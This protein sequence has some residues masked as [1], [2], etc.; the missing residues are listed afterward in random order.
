MLDEAA[1]VLAALHLP[2]D[3]PDAYRGCRLTD[4]ARRHP[5]TV[6]APHPGAHPR[7]LPDHQAWFAGTEF[8]VDESV[9]VPRSPLAE[10]VET[11]FGPRW[12]L[13]PWRGCL[14]CAP[15]VAV[16]ASPPR[17]TCRTRT[18]TWR[19][20]PRRPGGGGAQHR[21]PWPGRPG[22][23]DQVGPLRRA[24]GPTLRPDRQ[25]PALCQRRGLAHPAAGVPP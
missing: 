25:Q 4:E 1:L 8:C 10:L 23:G 17:S 3:L 13:T 16:S 6:R 22:A 20:S 9:L 19:T 12:S 2:P 15:A 14:T 18:W 21:R 5:R 11:G 24:G 7:R